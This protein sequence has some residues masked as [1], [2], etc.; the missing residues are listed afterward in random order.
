[1]IATDFDREGELIGREAVDL[2]DGKFKVSRVRFSSLVDEEIKKAFEEPTY[3]DQN[4]ADA[5]ETRQWIDLIWG[6]C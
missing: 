1:V 6:Q 2:I 5:A 3:L 4:L